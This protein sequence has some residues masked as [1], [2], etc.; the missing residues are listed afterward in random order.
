M[1]T[2]QQVCWT[3]AD[4]LNRLQFEIPFD[5]ELT[6]WLSCDTC[7]KFKELIL[8]CKAE[9]CK[10]IRFR[11]YVNRGAFLDDAKMDYTDL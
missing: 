5:K 1:I 6:A 11:A 9:I 3:F 7:T 2:Y 8:V 10:L 4:P